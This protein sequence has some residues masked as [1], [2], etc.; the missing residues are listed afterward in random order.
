MHE[1]RGRLETMP[2]RENF[3]GVDPGEPWHR[4]GRARL[5]AWVFGL[6]LIV[7]LAWTGL[8]PV[9]Y[10]SGATVLMTAPRAIDAEISDA[11]I[12]NVA[13]Q[14][15]ILLGNEIIARLVETSDQQG[16]NV[17]A[18]DLRNM[19]SVQP[20]PETNLVELSARGEEEERLPILV[21]DWISVYMELRAEDIALNKDRTSNAVRGEIDA[22]AEKLEQARDALEQ[23]RQEHDILSVER[24]ENVVMARLN[25][26]NTS[27]N[28]AIEE[29]VKARANL[30]TMRAASQ[31]G[32]HLVP[33]DQRR[34]VTALENELQSLRAQHVEMKK[35]Y[36]MDYI[37]RQPQFRMV[38][39]RIAELE[40][41]LADI[42]RQGEQAELASAEQTYAAAQQ[43]VAELQRK[44][45]EHKSSVAEFNRI[46][47]THQALANDLARL[48]ELHREA[49]ARL[50][51]MQVSSVEKY[52]QV[53]VIEQ[54][55]EAVRV[56]PDYLLLV[57]GTLLAALGLGVFSVWLT[58]FLSARAPQP[59]Y[60]TLSGVHLYPR[61]E[62]GQLVYASQA[63]LRL[64]DDRRS[65][66]D[67]PDEDRKKGEPV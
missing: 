50:V 21:N 57:G 20:V 4:S 58:G 47:A 56:G 61:E 41:E 9:V 53:A 18:V 34:D 55:R 17:S 28:D 66:G 65:T 64:G 5:F 2:R 60:V 16:T 31:R 3:G 30:D 45:D 7:G 48:E 10:S 36:T 24:P 54:A 19:L 37:D 67:D 44:L 32:E 22:L 12:Q 43:T 14:R 38:R 62:G 11:D 29:E 27:L 25:G 35:R 42:Y 39:E 40:L 8:Q 6:T 59:S 63:D 51:Q 26:L 23:Y 46:Y 49:Q 52:P 33:R 13:I 1:V 15:T